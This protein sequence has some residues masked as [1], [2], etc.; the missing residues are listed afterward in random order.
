MSHKYIL[1]LALFAAAAAGSVSAQQNPI[2]ASLVSTVDYKLYFVNVNNNTYPICMNMPFF[3][4][5]SLADIVPNPQVLS[6][7]TCT[8]VSID[9]KTS[10]VVNA[11]LDRPINIT[12]RMIDVLVHL[13]FVPCGAVAVTMNNNKLASVHSCAFGTPAL[14][15]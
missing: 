10:V 12:E 2:N 4:P 14:C 3:F 7:V 13:N 15:C 5:K 6:I 9:N 8:P 11:F 1:F